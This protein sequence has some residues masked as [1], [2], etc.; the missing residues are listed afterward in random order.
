MFEQLFGRTPDVIQQL[1]DDHRRV[2]ALFAAYEEG[3]GQKKKRV[4]QRVINELT[5][6]ADI[7]ERIVYPAFQK[8]FQDKHLVNQAFEEHHLV[9]IL[10]N[11]L[12]RLA[13]GPAF[14][15]KFQVLKEVI[16]HH[17]KEEE[18]QVFPAAEKQDNINW[19]A[20]NRQA[21]GVRTRRIFN[22]RKRS[23]R[24]GSRLARAA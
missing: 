3:K 20:L 23:A 4:A 14:D 16:Q 2:D 22:S 11:A 1:K 5:V 24:F 19:E 7:E 8:S 15:A 18:A 10:L 17:V 21:R 13:M 9:H 12:K 6:H